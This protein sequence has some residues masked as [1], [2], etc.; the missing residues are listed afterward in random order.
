[1][2][3]S[4]QIM[5]PGAFNINSTHLKKIQNYLFDTQVILGK[6]SFSTVHPG[7]HSLTSN[8]FFDLDEPIAV[9]VVRLDSLTS[10]KRADLLE[11][12]ISILCSMSHPSIIRCLEVLKSTNNCYIITELCE[13][14]NLEGFL[15]QRKSISEEEIWPYIRDIHQGLKYLSSQ[16]IIHRDLKTANIFLK[17]GKVKIADFG[18]AAHAR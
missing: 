8:S 3:P 16:C 10:K 17:E 14:G 9:K 4:S 12:E 15:R 18:F 7:L 5:A 11:D 13:Q 6:G 2:L 1:M